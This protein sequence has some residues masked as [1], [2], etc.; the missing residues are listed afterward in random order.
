MSVLNGSSLMFS[1]DHWSLLQIALLAMRSPLLLSPTRELLVQ[2]EIAR[3]GTTVSKKLCVLPVSVKILVGLCIVFSPILLFTSCNR[4][5]SWLFV[6]I[7]I[8]LSFEPM[9]TFWLRELQGSMLDYLNFFAAVMADL[10]RMLNLVGVGDGDCLDWK[11]AFTWN[12]LCNGLVMGLG[13]LSWASISNSY[14]Q[15]RYKVSLEL[16]FV[17]MLI[18]LLSIRFKS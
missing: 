3:W 15:A 9:S 18:A 8:Y 11:G 4:C 1:S 2:Y 7:L 5:S 14:K 10:G 12:R 13:V 6:P 17:Q 16:T